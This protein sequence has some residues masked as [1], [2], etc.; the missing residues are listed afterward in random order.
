M[1]AKGNRKKPQAAR[2]DAGAPPLETPRRTGRKARGRTDPSTLPPSNAA[3]QVVAPDAASL[4]ADG[5]ILVRLRSLVVFPGVVL[6]ITLGRASSVQA[7][8]EAVRRE[9]PVGLILQ[10]DP[11][12]DDPGPEDLCRVGTVASVLRYVTAPDGTHHTICQGQQRFR[13]VEYLRLEPYLA[14]RVEFLEDSTERP[15]EVDALMLHVKE[16]AKRALSLLP[17]QAPELVAAVDQI[18]APGLLADLVAAYMDLPV[19]EK[20]QVLETFDLVA[21]LNL[22]AEKLA[23][24]IEVLALSQ[25]ISERTKGKLD[26][27]QRDYYLREQLKTIQM[28]LGEEDHR[29]VEVQEISQKITQAAMPEVVEKEARRELARLE[30]MPE[31]AAE[32]S[33]VRTFLDWLTELPWARSTGEAIDIAR[34]R[35]VLDEDHF[36]LEKVKKRILEFLAVRKLKP[37]GKSPILCLVGPPGVGKT[38]LG[39][40]IAKALGRKFVRVSL[41]GVHDEA[42][43]RGHRRTYIGSLPG[44]VIQGIRR[45]DS[46]NPVFMLDE[47]DKMSASFHGDPASALLEVLDPEQNHAFTDHYLGV[48]FDLSRVFFIAT[49]NVLDTIPGPLR[50]RCEV[51]HLSGYTEEEKIEI[52]RRYLVGRQVD[53][54]GLKPEDVSVTD[55]ALVTVVREYTREA[56]CRGLE[57]EVGA[58]LRSVAVDVAA[59]KTGAVSLGEDDVHRILGAPRFENEAALR[60]STPGVATGLAWT[61]AGGELLFVEVTRMPGKGELILT[62]QLGDVMKESARA[63]ISLV[64]SRA[65]ELG[66]AGDV[67]TSS[68]IHIHVPAGA[69]PKDGPSAGV[70]LYVALVSLLTG[71]RVRSDVAMT[72]EISLRGLVLP[73]GGVKEKVLAAHAAGIDKVLLPARNRRDLE[74]IPKGARERLRL[75]WVENVAEAAREAMDGV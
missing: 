32:Y 44:N 15:K 10:R 74:D 52:A 27:A 38:S 4:P 68:D 28:E 11:A 50:D 60:T 69:I 56:G 43:I 73:V 13:V 64:K 45:A 25:E 29:S 9:A 72:G 41:G 75:V 62:G 1:K 6:P 33:M 61:P 58:L 57:R 65:A 55:A 66:I 20:Q 37:E 42:E 40:S 23:R 63:A 16:Q 7:V 70:T 31:G 59:G 35:Q 24:R 53:A 36:D 39:Q 8:Q 19:E 2:S 18:E 51:I 30:R 21:R 48:P 22:V 67:F 3:G 17:Q 14:A 12:K 54:S 5:L 47:I 26:K 71:K 34:A 49:A 46:R